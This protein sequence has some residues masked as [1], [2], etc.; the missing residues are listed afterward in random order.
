MKTPALP[1]LIGIGKYRKGTRGMQ[2]QETSAIVE[3]SLRVIWGL[4]A[5]VAPL[6][7]CVGGGSEE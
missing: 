7:R 6:R 4:G 1:Q 3:A 2:H 5:D